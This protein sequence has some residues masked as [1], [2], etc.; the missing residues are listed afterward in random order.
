MGE[1]SK[2]GQEKPKGWFRTFL[3]TMPVAEGA[4]AALD[5]ITE[6]ELLK[7]V[8]MVSTAIGAW[9]FR[10]KYKRAKFLKRVEEFHSQADDLT[11]EELDAFDETFDSVDEAEL[12][13]ADL[14]ELMDR[15]ENEQKAKMVGGAFKRLVRKEIT[16]QNF[17]E[18]SRVFDLMDNPH[19]FDFMHGYHNQAVYEKSLGDALVVMRACY[20]KFDLA[21]RN[22]SMFESGEVEQYVK[23]VYEITPFGRLIL[24][25]L[26]Q[27]YAD[28]I[29]SEHL[30]RSGR[31]G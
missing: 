28:K 19:I 13:V 20:R 17:R 2:G 30:V 10:N 7:G 24:E 15:L 31:M 5:A 27:V 1:I 3:K 22:R 26:H 18:I 14:L 21:E 25:T 11:R 12:F 6:S 16:K 29:E 23:V 8:P 9:E 4:E